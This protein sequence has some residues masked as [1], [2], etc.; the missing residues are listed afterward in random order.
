MHAT[1]L[2]GIR[3][4]GLESELSPCGWLE[5]QADIVRCSV[6]ELPLGLLAQW[7]IDGQ[8]ARLRH[9]SGGFFAVGSAEV[10]STYETTRRWLQPVVEQFEIGL[11]GMLARRSAR[12]LELLVQAKGEPGD[13]MGVQAAPTVQATR[14]NY[15]CVHQ[16]ALPAYVDWFRD[17]NAPEVL[18]DQLQPE[19]GSF[20]LR[21]FNRNMVI[22][23]DEDVRPGPRFRWMTLEEIASLLRRPNCLNMSLRSLLACLAG[24]SA[25]RH[26]A[27]LPSWFAEYAACGRLHVRRGGIDMLKA[28]AGLVPDGAGSPFDIIGV[29]VESKDREVERWH[30]PI[31]R[32][33]N[34]RVDLFVRRDTRG[35]AFLVRAAAEPGHRDW[36]A[37]GPS[38]CSYSSDAHGPTRADFGRHLASIAGRVRFDQWLSEDGGRFAGFQNR[39]RVIE[40]DEEAVGL[41]PP[42]YGWEEVGKLQVLAGR[43]LATI[44]LRSLLAWHLLDT[45]SVDR[46]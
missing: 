4:A 21:K 23:V 9:R 34:G 27:S 20:F 26:D 43:G 35:Q 25:N 15:L 1:E 24:A 17:R 11:L 7:S 36:L 16:G 31:I 10:A 5:A 6:E 28:E 37:L 3:T 30:Q 12:G 40:I 38:W 29:S 2:S 8:P 32:A 45:V 33:Q 14:S 46:R 22:L 39:F 41:L 18:L 42:G 13:L 19:H 44:E